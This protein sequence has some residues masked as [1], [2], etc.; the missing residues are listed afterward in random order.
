[1]CEKCQDKGFTEENHGLIRILCDCDKAR[2]VVER[3]GIPWRKDDSGIRQP[4]TNTG[5]DNPSEPKQLSKRKARRK[6]AK[7]SG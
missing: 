7:K 1:M 2:E 6:A 5:S 3:E 4:D